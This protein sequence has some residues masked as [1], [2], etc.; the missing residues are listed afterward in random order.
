VLLKHEHSPVVDPEA[1]PCGVS[2]LSRRRRR[3][4]RKQ[5]RGCVDM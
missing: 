3:R 4:R 2:A 5:E 1:F